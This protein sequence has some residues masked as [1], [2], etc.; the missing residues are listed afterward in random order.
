MHVASIVFLHTLDGYASIHLYIYHI[1]TYIRKARWKCPFLIY[2][3]YYIDFVV[4]IFIWHFLFI[5]S[6]TIYIYTDHFMH[7]IFWFCFWNR[8]TL[9]FLEF[10]NKFV[11][12]MC[13]STCGWSAHYSSV[14]FMHIDLQ[15]Q[16]WKMVFRKVNKMTFDVHSKVW[17]LF[18]V[19]NGF[20]F[21]VSSV[22][23]KTFV[24]NIFRFNF[25]FRTYN[26]RIALLIHWN[27][28]MSVLL[29]SKYIRK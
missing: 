13:N 11:S 8:K 19:E 15:L 17:S 10:I 20:V 2:L 18:R 23:L 1:Y 6:H 14:R 12:F 29:R 26:E 16:N 3:F 28:L 24:C 4:P 22:L 27:P 9:C 25:S 21:I 5:L 7:S